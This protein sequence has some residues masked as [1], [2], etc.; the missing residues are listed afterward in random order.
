MAET[1]DGH[2]WALGRPAKAARAAL[3]PRRNAAGPRLELEGLAF[4]RRA[5]A[6]WL[7]WSRWRPRESRAS[8]SVSNRLGEVVEAGLG[9]GEEGFHQR[10]G[11]HRFFCAVLGGEAIAGGTGIAHL[12]PFSEPT[13][14]HRVG[15]SDRRNGRHQQKGSTQQV[16]GPWSSRNAQPRRCAVRQLGHQGRRRQRDEVRGH[17]PTGSVIRSASGPSK[18]S[19]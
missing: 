16:G 6:S 18:A 5:E 8:R 15:G 17:N 7:A 10:G 3:V 2:A 14:H 4:R 9:S 13:V 1:R 11:D 19:A 12:R